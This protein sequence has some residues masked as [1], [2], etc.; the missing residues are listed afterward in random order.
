MWTR[1]SS[2]GELIALG[3]I[4]FAVTRSLDE[5]EQ[6]L[7]RSDETTVWGVGCHP[8]L[9]GVQKAFDPGRFRALAERTAYVGEIG[10]GW[11]IKGSYGGATADAEEGPRG[12]PA[13]AADHV[14]TQ[15]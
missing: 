1:E 5:A 4:V 6:A 10:A 14:A 11:N 15:L 12:A 9:V 2:R 13:K 8:R 7:G 3:A